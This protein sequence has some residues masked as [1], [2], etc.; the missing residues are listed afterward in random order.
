MYTKVWA[1]QTVTL[2]ANQDWTGASSEYV[3][4]PSNIHASSTSSTIN[5]D[6][7]GGTLN[8][9]NNLPAHFT[10]SVTTGLGTLL[11]WQSAIIPP[12]IS[13]DFDSEYICWSRLLMNQNSNANACTLNGAGGFNYNGPVNRCLGFESVHPP[14]DSSMGP[15]PNSASGIC[16]QGKS[17]TFAG[18]SGPWAF[19][20][21]QTD[22]HGCACTISHA[23]P[24]WFYQNPVAPSSTFWEFCY[25]EDPTTYNAQPQDAW[26]SYAMNL[27]YFFSPNDIGMGPTHPTLNYNPKLVQLQVT[28]PSCDQLR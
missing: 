9:G 26:T 20:A 12:S 14:F 4:P 27:P 11:P 13:A 19:G 18:N 2:Y 16:T 10:K 3:T 24:I 15:V 22:C 23:P 25:P 8:S 7:T 21:S 17:F 1:P 6:F 5:C 28:F